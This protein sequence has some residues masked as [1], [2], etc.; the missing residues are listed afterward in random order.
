MDKKPNRFEVIKR[1]QFRAE[2]TM[3]A[4]KLFVHDRR[5]RQGTKTIHA[6]LVYSL[7]V[8]MLTF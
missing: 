2:T 5:Q 4:Q 8:F 7:G 3:N 1:V 6:G